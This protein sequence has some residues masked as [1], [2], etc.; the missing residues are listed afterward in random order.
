MDVEVLASDDGDLAEVRGSMFNAR[1]MR[2]A[3]IQNASWC[4]YQE[5]VL[6]QVGV[7]VARLLR[8]GDRGRGSGWPRLEA[9]DLLLVPLVVLVGSLVGGGVGEEGGS[10]GSVFRSGFRLGFCFLTKGLKITR[11]NLRSIFGAKNVTTIN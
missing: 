6:H 3:S 11:Q 10:C 7:G 9:V 2:G 1:G 4:I 5:S 8:G